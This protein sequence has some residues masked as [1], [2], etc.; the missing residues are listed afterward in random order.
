MTWGDRIILQFT[1]TL[2]F[3]NDRVLTKLYCCSNNIGNLEL[4]G[5]YDGNSLLC[6][7]Q[8]KEGDEEPKTDY[9]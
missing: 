1:L 5:G 9:P 3:C 2:S 7:V 4:E 8:A 6:E